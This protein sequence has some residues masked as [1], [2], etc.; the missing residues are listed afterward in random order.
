MQF[1]NSAAQLTKR[2]N[3]DQIVFAM[4]TR[5]YFQTLPTE[6]VYEQNFKQLMHRDINRFKSTVAKK[7]KET[8]MSRERADAF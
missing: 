4:L 6:Q 1:V 7:R 3:N 2:T 8:I 5:N